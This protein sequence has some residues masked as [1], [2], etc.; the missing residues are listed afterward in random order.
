[1]LLLSL[2]WLLGGV[3]IGLVACCAR[4]CPPTWQRSGW[5]RM[6]MVGAISAL[7]GGW[8]GVLLLGN[9]FA[10]AMA[11]WIAVAGVVL[12]PQGV[13]RLYRLRSNS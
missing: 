9:F 12:I 8:L 6:L 7:G 3:L 2:F 4:L 13:S 1:M 10:T 11:L 5:L